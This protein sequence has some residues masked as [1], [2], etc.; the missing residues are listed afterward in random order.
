MITFLQF[1]VRNCRVTHLRKDYY[2]F[3]NQNQELTDIVQYNG[4]MQIM[5]LLTAVRDK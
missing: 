1:V 2:C 3:I 5:D 4:C